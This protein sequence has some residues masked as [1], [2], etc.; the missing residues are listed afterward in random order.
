MVSSSVDRPSNSGTK[1]EIVSN[2]TDETELWVE[3]GRLW[4]TDLSGQNPCP[5]LLKGKTDNET[6]T[7]PLIQQIDQVQIINY[8]LRKP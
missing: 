1:S 2:E 7:T 8:C 4:P 5:P 3:S 6:K